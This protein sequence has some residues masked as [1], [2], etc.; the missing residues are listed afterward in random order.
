MHAPDEIKEEA[1]QEDPQDEQMQATE[2]APDFGDGDLDDDVSETSSTQMRRANL[3]MNSGV[4][5]QYA[6]SENEEEEESGLGPRPRMARPAMA[7]FLSQFLHSDRQFLDQL[8]EADS[9][10]RQRRHEEGNPFVDIQANEEVRYGEELEERKA[11]DIFAQTSTQDFTAALR[12]EA[13][14][15]IS[16]AQSNLELHLCAGRENYQRLH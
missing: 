8:L 10:R 1:P 12:P 14:E 2:E 13:D 6:D 15:N 11:Q 9:A 3:L 4:L 5:Q 16:S 7:R